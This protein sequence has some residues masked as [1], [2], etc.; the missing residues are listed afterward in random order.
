MYPLSKA[1]VNII[2]LA[3][4]PIK[5]GTPTKENKV[6]IKLKDNIGFIQKYPFN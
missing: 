6:T 3:K 2:C 1:V 5:G 4:N